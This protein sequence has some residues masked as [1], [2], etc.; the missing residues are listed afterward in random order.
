MLSR[1][2]SAGLVVVGSGVRSKWRRGSACDPP[3]PGRFGRSGRSLLNGSPQQ[4]AED[5]AEITLRY[6]VI[7][8]IL[9]ADDA[10]SIEL[11][12][13]E[14]APATRELVAAERARR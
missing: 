5:L 7:S 13:A 14:V 8:F 3:G 2:Y 11:F 12:A 10:P 6:G 9:A 4:W 1:S